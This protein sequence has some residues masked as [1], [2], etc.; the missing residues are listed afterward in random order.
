MQTCIGVRIVI[1]GDGESKSLRLNLGNTIVQYMD[2]QYGILPRIPDSIISLSIGGPDISPEIHQIT[3]RAK[4]IG[5]IL[6][7]DFSTPL[8]KSAVRYTLEIVFGYDGVASSGPS[9][10][11]NFIE[12]L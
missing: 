10:E 2:G 6:F 3:E 12:L 8:L 7:L 5:P 1:S 4:I 9:P 11:L